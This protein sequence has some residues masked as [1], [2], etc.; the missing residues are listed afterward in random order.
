MDDEKYYRFTI[1]IGAAGKTPEAAWLE[2][3]EGFALDYGV[4]PDEY[5]EEEEY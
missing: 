1:T 4:M 5:E 3:C 2:A